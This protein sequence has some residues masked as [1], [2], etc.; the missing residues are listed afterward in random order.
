MSNFAVC[1]RQKNGKFKIVAI[2][3]NFNSA[4]NKLRSYGFT[5]PDGDIFKIDYLAVKNEYLDPNLSERVT[6]REPDAHYPNPCVH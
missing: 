3:P 5:Y 2:Q 1:F 4:Y 6:W